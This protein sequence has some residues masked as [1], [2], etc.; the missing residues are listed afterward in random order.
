MSYKDDRPDLDPDPEV[1]DRYDV[2]R[3]QMAN[4]GR[5]VLTRA[6]WLNAGQF[7]LD[8]V[9]ACR[10]VLQDH[11]HHTRTHPYLA[12]PLHGKTTRRRPDGTEEVVR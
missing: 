6:A 5:G 3:Q 10:E 9:C 4:Q 8:E 2:Y 1:D 12:C 7:I 11:I